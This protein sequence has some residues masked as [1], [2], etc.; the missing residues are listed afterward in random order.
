MKEP[1]IFHNSE[2][3]KSTHKVYEQLFEN[4]SACLR[5]FESEVTTACS[6]H[7]SA[8]GE[9]FLNK[10]LCLITKI[11]TIIIVKYWK[12]YQLVL[13]CFIHTASTGRQVP[14]KREQTELAIRLGA[15]FGVTR[16]KEPNIF[17]ASVDQQRPA[18]KPAESGW[19]NQI[20]TKIL[21]FCITLRV[22]FDVS[23]VKEPNI[24]STSVYQPRRSLKLAES[25]WKNQTLTKMLLFCI[26]MRV[27]FDETRVKEPN[28]FS[29]SVNQPQKRRQCQCA[30]KFKLNRSWSLHCRA[31]KHAESGWKNQTVAQ[32]L[33][34]I[35]YASGTRCLVRLLC[36]GP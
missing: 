31:L 25:G 12:T 4:Y 10:I 23:R 6:F 7:H 18:L 32:I 13:L 24:F 21:L 15:N 19:K 3:E 5:Y 27:N 22:N 9:Y 11:Y 17:S 20:L 14:L 34:C 30:N 26:S 35:F 28:I 8:H 2:T 1:N 29:A 16:V 33:F 36:P